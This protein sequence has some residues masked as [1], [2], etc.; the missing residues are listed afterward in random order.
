MVDAD[1][2]V[3]T[4]APDDFWQ[5][6]QPLIPVPAVRPQGGGKRRADGRA[7]LAAIVY[8]VQAGCS[9]PK[10]PAVLITLTARALAAAR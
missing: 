5:E 6:A 4:G 3:R 7:V 9:W 10:L 1:D 2:M 8:L